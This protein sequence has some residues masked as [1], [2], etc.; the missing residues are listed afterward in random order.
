MVTRRRFLRTA[1]AGMAGLG[2]WSVWTGGLRAAGRPSPRPRLGINLAGIADWATELPF[3]DVLRCA[4]PWISQK[5]GAGWGR[6]PPLDLDAHGWVR[7]LEPGCW[8]ETLL[9][10]IPDGHYP[11]GRYTVLWKGRGR[12]E[13][14]GG[15]V[16]VERGRGRMVLEVGGRGAF[17]LRLTETDPAD[18]L[19]DLHVIMPGFEKTW[20]TD[21]F[22]PTF[23]RR[24][25]GMACLRFMDWMRTNGSTVRTWADHPTPADATFSRRGVPLEWMIDLAN[26]LGVAP[27][28]CMP[29]MADDDFVRR[30]AGMVR[31]RLDPRL[32]VYLE[33]SNEVWNGIFPQSRWAGEQGRR[34]GFAEKPWEAAW[35]F[36]AYRSLQIFKIWEEVFGGRGRLVR[37]LPSQAANPYVAEVILGFRDAARRADALAIA[38]YMGFTVGRGRLKDIG[39][40]MKD[41]SVD[42][43]LD[44]FEEHAFRPS[45]RCMEKNK[46]VADRYGLRLVAYEG[47]QHMVALVRDRDLADRLTDLFKAANRH[48]RMGDLYTRYFD[49][50]AKVGGDLFAVFSSISRWGRHGC[51]GL[52]EFY[53]SP[54]EAYPKLAATLRWARKMGQPVSWLPEAPTSRGGSA[55]A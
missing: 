17:H 21:P 12:L 41:W 51:W 4:R 5:K 47:G 19:R 50:W 54:P 26:R 32:P 34:L 43:V 14:W 7:R 10:T 20:R 3:V 27:W 49:H 39:P 15:P 25:R 42:Q 11:T 55:P 46:A 38:P 35:R 52:A 6:G 45:L 16:V 23:L 29:H 8:A 44:Y 40:A 33:Y 28:F 48:P 9:C 1:T 18:P 37:L 36:T 22:H 13:P 24:W 30:F 31:E 53:D 2:G